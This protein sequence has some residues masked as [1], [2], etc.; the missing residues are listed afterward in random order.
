MEK[1][2]D[3]SGV[4]EAIDILQEHFRHDEVELLQ[5]DRTFLETLLTTR[6]YRMAAEQRRA[7][8]LAKA[9]EIRAH[10]DM[11]RAAHQLHEL[12]TILDTDTAHF[13]AEKEDA[14][15]LCAEAKAKREAAERELALKEQLDKKRRLEVTLETA[16][17]EAELE[18]H[19]PK[20]EEPKQPKQERRKD[21]HEEIR[22]LQ[23]AKEREA[24]QMHT[25][26]IK[27]DNPY[28]KQRMNEYDAKINELRRRL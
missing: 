13:T 8:L 27:D 25:A 11:L 5:R 6:F 2:K 15:R 20:P 16:K 7:F 24:E 4:Q 23:K 17:L 3:S 12:P 21:P 26:D 22:N 14:K 10:V 9:G 28:F 1:S 19:K 18:S